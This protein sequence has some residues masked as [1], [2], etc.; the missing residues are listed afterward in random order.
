MADQSGEENK[1]T[2]INTMTIHSE[3]MNADR[4][5]DAS[6]T[7]N[8]LKRA[9]SNENLS[10]TEQETNKRLKKDDIG[11]ELGELK[12][13]MYDLA[14]EMKDM[15][16]KVFERIENLENTFAKNIVEN[17]S[18][19]IDNKINKEV[20][21]VKDDFKAQMT[22]VNKRIDGIVN[23]LR[24][25]IKNIHTEV[26]DRVRT[27]LIS[28]QAG[29]ITRPIHRDTKFVVKM[30]S[31][32]DAEKTDSE[33]TKNWVSAIIRDGLRLHDVR[34]VKATRMESKG[35]RPG[36]VIASVENEEQKEKLMK[37]KRKL[38]YS[39]DYQKVYIEN[40]LTSEVVEVDADIRN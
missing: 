1:Q 6:N 18:K 22:T 14:V 15:N 39:R 30:L 29:A 13:L 20:N 36:R 35:N 19:M 38:K 33:L 28:S 4:I 10:E 27:D 11:N 16:D 12:T 21:K 25:D 24:S 9:R 37:S 23:K 7:D 3:N 8:K 32:T 26:A 5:N 2:Q 31:E 40:E 34:V 17:M